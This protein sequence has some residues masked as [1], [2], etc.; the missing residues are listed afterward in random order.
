MIFL[1]RESTGM[2]VSFREEGGSSLTAPLLGQDVNLMLQ[3]Q[4]NGI[5]KVNDGI[6]EDQYLSASLSLSQAVQNLENVQLQQENDSARGPVE[7]EVG[8]DENDSNSNSLSHPH[9]LRPYAADCSFY[10]KTGTCGFG[11][12]CRFN[13]PLPKPFQVNGDKEKERHGLSEDGVKIKCKY[14]LTPG[15]CKFGASC[16]YDHPKEE[17]ETEPP[18][19]NFLGLPIRLGEKECPFY[20]RHGSCKYEASCRFHHP[21]PSGAKEE[22]NNS[23]VNGE[24]AK[25]GNYS[26]EKCIGEFTSTHSSGVVQAA[27]TSVNHRNS[28]NGP[29]YGAVMN[30]SRQG[31]PQNIGWNQYQEKVSLPSNCTNPHS[32][33]GPPHFSK[34]ADSTHF[35]QQVQIEEFPERPGQ[36]ECAY[37]MKT[38]NCKYKSACRYH[39]PGS[40]LKTDLIRTDY[41]VWKSADSFT[42]DQHLMQIQE[43][44]ERP[45]QPDCEYFMK[46]GD[47][48]FRTACR[49]NHPRSRLSQFP[50]PQFGGH[51]LPSGP[52]AIPP[53]LNS[54]LPYL[55]PNYINDNR[56]K[57]F[58]HQQSQIPIQEFPER[59]G[60]PECDYYMKTGNCKYKSA[61][62]Y[63][64]P[65]NRASKSP[66][67]A[68]NEKG[69]PL[70]PGSKICWHY[71]QQG[72]CKF[73]IH[74]MFDHPVN[75][76]AS[77][78][79]VVSSDVPV[80]PASGS[81]SSINVAVDDW[82]DWV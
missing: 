13:H 42:Q 9:P 45:G 43:F 69:L 27:V 10:L 28:E 2:G 79:P 48:K 7:V 72:F 58:A 40:R 17:T 50:L 44:P 63:H 61:C 3:T 65:T 8:K 81:S 76:S 64:H 33:H 67:C 21:E 19:L 47:C 59:P 53:L 46:T 30:A 49:Y 36:P 22:S 70:R 39:H 25:G 16:K 77:A 52:A 18:A 73:G 11:L 57:T 60:Q 35:Q 54:K 29:C 23:P 34:K 38:G 32:N 82:C 66:P 5:H 78:V 80:V 74:C 68:L 56:T 26:S 14:Y 41:S 20:M 4:S 12:N 15:G 71:E 24:S 62:H 31:M 1:E 75:M 51:S 55:P 37:F 6:G